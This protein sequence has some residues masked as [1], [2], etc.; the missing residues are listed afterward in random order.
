MAEAAIRTRAAARPKP[1]R[2]GFGRLLGRLVALIVIVAV[3]APPLGALIYRFVPPPI[4]ILMIER[5]AQLT[6]GLRIKR[7]PEGGA[8]AGGAVPQPRRAGDGR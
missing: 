1:A 5:L 3:F 4:T 8:E 7:E 6:E 2:R